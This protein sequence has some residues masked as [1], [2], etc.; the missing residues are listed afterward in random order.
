MALFQKLVCIV[1]PT[2][3]PTAIIPV[4]FH[5]QEYLHQ[6]RKA[7]LHAFKRLKGQ[8]HRDSLLIYNLPFKAAK[9][10]VEEY[11][12]KFGKIEY[13]KFPYVSVACTFLFSKTL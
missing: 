1:R 13:I 12:V 4:R 7:E 5:F 6:R 3:Q 2:L 11:F 10:D 8:S 9:E